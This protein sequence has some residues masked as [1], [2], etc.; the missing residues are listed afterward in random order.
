MTF[1]ATFILLL[2]AVNPACV[3]IKMISVDQKTQ[4]ENQILGSF[5]ALQGDLVLIAS[6][7]GEGQTRPDLPPAKREALMAMMNRQFN[8]DDLNDLR[9]RGIAGEKQDG[10][11]VMRDTDRT[12][13]DSAYAQFARGIIDQENRDRTII[14]NRVLSMNPSLTAADM[15]IVR[16][17]MHK[18]AAESAPPGTPIEMEN[19][20]WIIKPEAI[21]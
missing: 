17:M 3:S 10:L 14:M 6:V 8:L 11:L 15:P 12:R 18:L 20:Q 5:E 1:L 4:L 21:K 2:V 19:G 9:R 7:R 16:S 13:G